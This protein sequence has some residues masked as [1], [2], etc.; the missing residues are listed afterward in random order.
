MRV[1]LVAALAAAAGACAHAPRGGADAPL[2]ARLNVSA[3]GMD[4]G[5]SDEA[6]VAVF[7]VTPGQGVALVYPEP[8]ERSSFVAGWN[9]LDFGDNRAAGSPLSMA[10]FTSRSASTILVLVASRQP[11]NLRRFASGVSLQRAM[12]DA[13]FR[14][15]DADEVLAGIARL[16]VT[17]VE[18]GDWA[19][20][21]TAVPV[22]RTSTGYAMA[23]EGRFPFENPYVVVQCGAFTPGGA[24]VLVHVEFA[25]YACTPPERAVETDSASTGD[26]QSASASRLAVTR[27]VFEPANAAARETARSF[28]GSRAEQAREALERTSSGRESH[29]GGQSGATRGHESTGP[30]GAGHDAGRTR[31]DGS[32]GSRN[33]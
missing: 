17:G 1:L 22:V 24:T 7:A 33:P 16:T 6:N 13:V 5:L 8:H 30:G 18:E 19:M 12:G 20:D 4:V 29:G 28:R 14:A 31:A 23:N 25:A 3:S 11:L 15:N 27:R 9:T 21:V 10:Q 32:G 26:G 2:A